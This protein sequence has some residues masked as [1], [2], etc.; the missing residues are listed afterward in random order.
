MIFWATLVH[1]IGEFLNFV[2]AKRWNLEIGVDDMVFLFFTDVVFSALKTLLY[3]LPIMALFAKVTPKKIEGTT[4][5]FLTGTMDL[6]NVVISPAMGTWIN[7]QFVGVNKNDLSN[8]P[9]LPLIATV[10]AAVSFIL[11]FLIPTKPQIKQFRKDRR[12][13][14]FEKKKARRIRRLEKKRARG[15]PI[16]DEEQAL[17]DNPE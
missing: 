6:A 3:T 8:Y 15:L 12:Q 16:A 7:H 11:V 13:H 2:F 1:V 10:C 5:A 4:F 9:T 14:Y 17:L